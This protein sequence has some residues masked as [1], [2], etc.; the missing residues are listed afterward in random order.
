M[1]DE[2]IGYQEALDLTLA[3]I[4]PLNSIEIPLNDSTNH[5]SASDVH[6]AVD[7]PSVNTSL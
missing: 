6:A 1:S 5:R 3:H 7:S 4:S 2:L